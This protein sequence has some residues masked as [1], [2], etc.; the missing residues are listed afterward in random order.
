MRE[1][2]STKNKKDLKVIIVLIS[3][4]NSNTIK[5]LII[6]HLIHAL[7]CHCCCSDSAQW[8]ELA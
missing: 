7:V 3:Q 1:E 8:V 4:H 6:P 2:Q 5:F